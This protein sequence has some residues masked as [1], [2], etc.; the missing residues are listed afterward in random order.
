[1]SSVDFDFDLRLHHVWALPWL[2]PLPDPWQPVIFVNIKKPIWQNANELWK[3]ENALNFSLPGSTWLW[4]RRSLDPSLA[5]KSPKDDILHWIDSG[6]FLSLT[7]SHQDVS[8]NEDKIF[9]SGET[10]V[11]R[12]QLCGQICPRKLQIAQGATTIIM[13]YSSPVNVLGGS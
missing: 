1:M 11:G 5:R 8:A 4:W 3:G 6:S 13:G 2:H 9:P 10:R 7:F 12:A